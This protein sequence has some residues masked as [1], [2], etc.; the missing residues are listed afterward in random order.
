ML[1][2]ILIRL[3]VLALLLATSTTQA[4]DT[5]LTYQG[6]LLDNG[7]PFTGTADLN[8]QLYDAMEGGSPVGSPEM[9]ADWPVKGGLFQ[10]ELDFDAAVFDGSDRFLQVEVNGAPL[11]PRQRV[12]A[13][14]YALLAAGTAAGAV[15]SSSINPSQVQRR[16]T[17]SCPSGQSIRVINQNGSVA[18]EADSSS[19]REE[20][21]LVRIIALS[22]NHGASSNL[23]L[24]VDGELATGLAI[25]FGRDQSAS[26]TVQRTT[27]NEN[28]I[29][30]FTDDFDSGAV[31]G[32][33]G[34]RR[35][36]LDITN[37]AYIQDF[38][39]SNGRIS[40]IETTMDSL[41]KGVFLPIDSALL[42]NLS[43]NQLYVIVRGDFVLDDQGRAVDAEHLRGQLPSGD[44]PAVVDRGVQG[45]RFE[46]WLAVQ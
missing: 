11:T 26:A 14:P 38:S 37:I 31:G 8:F 1:H 9:L 33:G 43:G 16:V 4:Q 19:P 3:L 27:L 25:G 28:T 36:R 30:V 20:E 12:T 42:S 17:G 32:E 5:A 46:S 15:D 2:K 34:F 13:S 23:L 6:Q 24:E 40:E 22:W 44:R 10:A 45:G 21:E 41:A 39:T 35:I 7:Q 18:C 29:Q